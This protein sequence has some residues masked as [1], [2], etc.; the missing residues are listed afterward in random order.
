[1][2]NAAHETG[3]VV[4]CRNHDHANVLPFRMRLPALE[5]TKTINAGHHDIEEDQIERLMLQRFQCV[6]AVHGTHAPVP[7][8]LELLLEQIEIKRLII[9]D[10]DPRL[11]QQPPSLRA[12]RS[13][14]TFP[15][16]LTEPPVKLGK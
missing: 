7:E 9:D 12:G 16:A 3:H 4:H 10:E 8:Q 15:S 14:A 13:S 1:I 5:H 6:S 11:L 2:R